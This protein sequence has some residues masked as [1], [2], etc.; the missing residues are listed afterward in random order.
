MC[1]LPR[2]K[3][4]YFFDLANDHSDVISCLEVI[5][6]DPRI[7]NL[8]EVAFSTPVGDTP[9]Y[10]NLLLQLCK[11][12]EAVYVKWRGPKKYRAATLRAGS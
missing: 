12:S 11:S 4:A 1:L 5:I 2:L 3:F 10:V 6:R 7:L 8:L 9:S